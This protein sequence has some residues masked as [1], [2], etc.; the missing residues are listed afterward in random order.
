MSGGPLGIPRP[1]VN[2][3]WPFRPPNKSEIKEIRRYHIEELGFDRDTALRHVDEEYLVVL[4]EF[5]P[6]DMGYKGKVAFALADHVDNWA[7][8]YW[9]D[10]EVE[11]MASEGSEL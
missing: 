5:V 3:G 9:P 2:R 11:I 6:D 8:Y 7:I 1:F 10:G 4:D